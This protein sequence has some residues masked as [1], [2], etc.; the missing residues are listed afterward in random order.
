MKKSELLDFIR[1]TYGDIW[2]AKDIGKIFR[3]KYGYSKHVI[4]VSSE[5]LTSKSTNKQV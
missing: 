5:E 2:I 1:R 3:K 4:P